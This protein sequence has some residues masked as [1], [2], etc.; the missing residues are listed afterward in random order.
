MLLYFANRSGGRRENPIKRQN[1]Q[2][3]GPGHLPV[4]A[5]CGIDA[6]DFFV[7]KHLD[8]FDGRER[9]FGAFPLKVDVVAPLG[10]LEHKLVCFAH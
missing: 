2:E 4:P 5:A 6:R 1:A 9:R 10:A 8:G 3:S 7:A